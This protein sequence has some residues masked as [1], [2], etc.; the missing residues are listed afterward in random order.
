MM[1]FQPGDVVTAI[2]PGAR[3]TKP[4]PALVVTTDLYHATRPDVV[5]G[6][7]TSQVSWATTPTDYV[8]QDWQA[9]RLLLPTA[10]RCYFN[11]FLA[12]HPRRIGRLTDRDW[13]EVQARLRL[14]LAV[15]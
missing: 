15:V 13:A 12:S 4:R 7:L 5:L 3:V 11:T 6:L 1:P 10:F 8:L 14:A 9:A 2:Y